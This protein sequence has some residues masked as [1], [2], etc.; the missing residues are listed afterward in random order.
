MQPIIYTIGHSNQAIDSLLDMLRSFEI[1]LLAD[2]RSYPA[3]RLWPQFN[4]EALQHSLKEAGITYLHMPLLGGKSTQGISYSHYMRSDIFEK[5]INELQAL[6]KAQ[7]VA[8][9]CAEADWQHCHRSHISDYLKVHGW[10]V[11]HI[12]DIGVFTPHPDRVKQT[13][14]F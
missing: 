5:A 2:V 4:R 8:Y 9:M 14:L 12:Q 11:N 13:K 3:S 1:Q 7:P 6:A 10:Q